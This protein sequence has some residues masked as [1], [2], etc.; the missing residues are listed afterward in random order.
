MKTHAKDFSGVGGL[1]SMHLVLGDPTMA[2]PL[3]WH[4]VDLEFAL[5]TAPAQ[6]QL[7]KSARINYQPLPE[8]RHQFRASEPRPPAILSDTFAAICA[9]PL[10]VLFILVGLFWN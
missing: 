10:L 4:F 8:I 1:Y 5:P 3:R 6:P 9:A 2:N 7:P